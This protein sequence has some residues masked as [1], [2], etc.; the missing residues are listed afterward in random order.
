M[1]KNLLKPYS[2]ILFLNSPQAGALILMIT[3]INPSVAFSGM[4]AVG[5]TIGFAK[6]LG[7]SEE[8]LTQGFY[9]YNSLLV[10]MGIGFIFMP[11][12]TSV[13]L[14]AFSASFTFALSFMLNR[15][16]ATYTIP[17]LSL[18]FSIVTMFV[19]LASLKYSA[20]LSTLVNNSS[21]YD[22]ALPIMLSSF[23]KSFGT[24]FFLPNNIAG[25]LLLSVVLYFSRIIFI[26]AV[27]GFYFGILIHSFF[28]GSLTQ[29]LYDPYAFNYILVAIAMCGIFLLPTIRNFIL[30]LIAVAISVILTDAI[31]ILFNYYAI[32]VFTLP[33]N[34]TVITFIFILSATYY[35]EFNYSIKASPEKSL[36]NY[37]STIFRFGE[38]PI[39]IELPFS[40]EW[41]VYQ[42][43]N[44]KWTHKGEY[45]FA[46]DFVKREGGKTFQNEGVHLNDYY[47]F[48]EPILAPVSGYIVETKDDL[49]DNCIGDVDRVN[50]WGNYIIIR[51]DEGFFVEISHLLQ[52]SISVK[53][54]DYITLNTIIAMCG[55]SGYSP[56]PHIHIQVQEL[57]ILGAFTKEFCFRS[58]LENSTLHFNGLPKRDEYINSTLKDPTINSRL[59][60]ILDDTFEY[61]LFENSNFIKNISFKI[62]MDNNSE[63]YFE[64]EAKNRLYFFNDASEFY[65]YNYVGESSH[66][67][68]LFILLPRL[69]FIHAINLKYNDF[70]PVYLIKSKAQ[71]IVIELLS[72]LNKKY[73]K[74][75]KSYSYN[76]NKI[77]SDYG[78][79][80]LSQLQKGFEIIK[81][82]NI[83]LKRI[84]P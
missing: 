23:F 12:L 71:T 47:S 10:G 25:I 31:A 55:N 82:E 59:T 62:K 42:A 43:F 20:L 2:S 32:P 76:Q 15:L 11:S 49:I 9:I 64:D 46:Y 63:F 56:E 60:F 34:I 69:P 13:A 83:E 54:G 58:Y 48:G 18:P 27:V 57:A 19:Y 75:I 7:M 36:S 78:K 37:L 21:M 68:A 80:E 8:F 66:L 22:I 29:A 28:I 52:Y 30:A 5:F 3:L 44:D 33:F 24:I 70:L 67:K 81:Y 72:S 6:L 41:S 50:N 77:S 45:K 61:E 79:V 17:I 51:S 16:F 4:L 26:M 84:N 35:K 38:I 40:G 53:T 73:Y 65:F 39:K 74:L 1:I 14:I